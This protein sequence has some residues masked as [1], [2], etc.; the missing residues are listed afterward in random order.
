[1]IKYHLKQSP[2][3]WVKKH[4]K[5]HQDD[6]KKFKDLDEWRPTGKGQIAPGEHSR[7]RL[8]SRRTELDA[9][10]QQETDN[11][12]C[13]TPIEEQSARGTNAKTVVHA[14]WHS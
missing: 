4:V 12:R 5:G 1:M 14:I 10:L 6:H 2:I 13:G 7:H 3:L 11:R 9:A 8:Y